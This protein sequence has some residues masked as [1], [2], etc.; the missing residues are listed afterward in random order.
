MIGI[1]RKAS[2]LLA[3][4]VRPAARRAPWSTSQM[5]TTPPSDSL[6][7]VIVAPFG[8]RVSRPLGSQRLRQHLLKRE[9]PCLT[10]LCS[11][12]VKPGFSREQGGQKSITRSE[13]RLPERWYA[14]IVMDGQSG[15]ACTLRQWNMNAFTPVRPSDERVEVAQNSLHGPQ[16]AHDAR[17]EAAPV[18]GQSVRAEARFVGLILL[19]HAPPGFLRKWCGRTATNWTMRLLLRFCSS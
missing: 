7:P 9:A 16:M 19:L 10:P 5:A 3:G 12:R 6:W 18:T 17:G 14:V 8:G 4:A 11:R 2:S 1:R 13:L 15:A